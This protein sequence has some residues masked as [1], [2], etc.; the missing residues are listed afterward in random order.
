[1]GLLRSSLGTFVLGFAACALVARFVLPSPAAAV[2]PVALRTVDPAD[3]VARVGGSVVNLETYPSSTPPPAVDPLPRLLGL[4]G[5]EEPDP[6]A[7]ASGVILSRRG[8]IVTNAHV[9]EDAGRVRARLSD[10]REF[11]AA[12]VGRDPHTDLAIVNIN[13]R[14]L[15]AAQLGESRHVR[16]GDQVLAIGNPLGFENSVSVGVVSANRSGPFRV[17]GR[18]LGDMIQTDAAINQGNSGGGLFAADGRLLGINTAIMVTRGASGSIG[19]GFA[20][21]AGDA[22]AVEQQI[23]GTD[24]ALA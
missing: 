21:P 24:V 12:I 14:G 1:M 11:D 17:D 22:L 23:L 19:I 3:V 9:V 8:Y 4:P 5:R 7:V 16:P 10:G 20:I 6:D 2:S 18:T 13:A 15:T